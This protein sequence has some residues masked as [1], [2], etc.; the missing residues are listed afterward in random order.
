MERI[1]KQFFT[2]TMLALGIAATVMAG[3]MN[4]V[5]AAPLAA[6]STA[7]K[8]AVPSDVTE[9]RRWRGRHFAGALLGLGALALIYEGS[10][11]HHRHHYHGGY[12][13]YYGYGYGPGCIRHRGHLYCR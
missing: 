9:V 6:S 10:R 3:A 1:M 4:P 12:Y 11:R 7:V 5:S 2:K 8:E 13:P